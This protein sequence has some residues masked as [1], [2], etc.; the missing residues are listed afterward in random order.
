MEFFIITTSYTILDMGRLV[1][2]P[3]E[4]QKSDEIY[5]CFKTFSK[6]PVQIYSTMHL[7]T[8]AVLLFKFICK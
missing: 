6:I 1:K 3:K 7:D 4:G 5:A 8:L 2:R